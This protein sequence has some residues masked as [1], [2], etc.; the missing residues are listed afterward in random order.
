[1]PS[2]WDEFLI[3]TADVWRFAPG[4][5]DDAGV[6]RPYPDAAPYAAGVA[7]YVENGSSARIYA[8]DRVIQEDQYTV[9]FAANAGFRLNDRIDWTDSAGA[10]HKLFVVG[11][12]DMIQTHLPGLCEVSA[13]ERS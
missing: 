4:Q 10:A 12:T 3:H 5:D 8:E 1:M 2:A 9:F 11:V 7:C 6:A 13:I